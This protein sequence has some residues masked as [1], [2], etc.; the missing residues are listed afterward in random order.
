MYKFPNRIERD[1]GY[2]A[3][4][5]SAMWLFVEAALIGPKGFSNIIVFCVVILASAEVAA[6]NVRHYT[7][8]IDEF[9]SGFKTKSATQ[10]FIDI[11]VIVYTVYSAFDSAAASVSSERTLALFILAILSFKH[12]VDYTID[13]FQSPDNTPKE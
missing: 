8:L 3:L 13:C 9:F 2:L 11:C 4:I 6:Y 12:M 1:L 10:E 5:A 7:I